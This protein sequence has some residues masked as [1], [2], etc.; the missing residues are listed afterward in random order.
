MRFLVDT[1]SN[2]TILSPTVVAKI[3]PDRQPTLESVE[4]HMIL[5][6][7]SAKPFCGRGT[8]EL[9][10]E[11]KRIRQEIWITDIELEGIL[12]MDFVHK[13]RCQIV[14]AAEGELQLF[15]PDMSTASKAELADSTV[16]TRV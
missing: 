5:A 6:D 9:E 16:F 12:G 8:F 1:G 2:I 14:S 7:G 13:Y 10:V 3:G 4:N 15:I 11:G